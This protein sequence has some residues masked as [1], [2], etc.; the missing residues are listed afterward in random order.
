MVID[1]VLEGIMRT[2]LIAIIAVAGQI[3]MVLVE[4]IIDLVDIIVMKM[5]SIMNLKGENQDSLIIILMRKEM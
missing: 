2:L 3:E 5:T 1:L 4:I